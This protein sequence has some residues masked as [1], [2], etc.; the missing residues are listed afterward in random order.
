MQKAPPDTLS[1]GA[2]F[3]AVVPR[4]ALVRQAG[5]QY[6]GTGAIDNDLLAEICSPMISEDMYAAICNGEIK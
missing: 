4:L 6:A 5:K 1:D 3:L 2:F